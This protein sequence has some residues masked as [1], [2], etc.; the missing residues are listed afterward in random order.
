MARSTPSTTAL[1]L[2]G[3]YE[4][5]K[6]AVVCEKIAPNRRLLS[7]VSNPETL[8][9]AYREIKG[10]KGALTPGAEVSEEAYNNMTSMQKELYLKSNKFPDGMNLYYIMLISKLLR[11]GKYPWGCP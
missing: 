5:N 10:N 9:L 4:K 2:Q 7:I 3:I 8:M 1:V 6:R 11:K